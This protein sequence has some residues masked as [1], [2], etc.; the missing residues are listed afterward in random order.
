MS[1]P[2]SAAAPGAI[3]TRQDFSRALTLLRESRSLSIR[4]VAAETGVRGAHTTIGDWFSGRGLPSPA[5]RD[6]LVGVLAACG[7]SADDEVEAWLAAWRRVRRTPGPRPAGPQPYRGLAGFRPEDAGWFFGREDVVE[8]LV[9]R[10]RASRG[11]HIVVGPSGA[12]K[13]SLLGAGLVPALRSAGA[14]VELRTPGAHPGEVLSGSS[15]VLIVDQLEEMFTACRDDGERNRF[16]AALAAAAE[17]GR[18]IVLGLRADFYGHVLRYPELVAAVRDGQLALGP[19]IDDELRRAVLEPARRARV[20]VE[21]GLV[22]LLLS[23]LTPP[24]GHREAG[25]LPLLSHALYATWR[26]SDGRR[27]TIA[28]YRAVGGIDGAVATTATTVYESLTEPQRILARRLFLSLVHVAPDT[29]DTRR[30]VPAA[31]LPAGVREVLDLFIDARLVTAD[32]DT[33]QLSHEALL[34][35]WPLLRGWLDTDRAGL[36]VGRPLEEAAATWQR[37]DRD[38]AALYRGTRL[39]I[40]TEWARTTGESTAPGEQ[41]REFLAA[42]TAREQQE[43]SAR[44]RRAGRLRRLVAALLVLL[45]VAVGAT[46]AAVRS[47]GTTREQRDAALSAKVAGD[48]TALRSSDPALAAQLGLAAYRLTPTTQ[49]RGALLSTFATPYSTLLPGHTG[50]VYAAAFH[51]GGRLL[52][53]TGTDATTRLWDT[54]DPHHPHVAGTVGDPARGGVLDAGFSPDGTLLATAGA[55]GAIRLWD[56]ADPAR[57]HLTTVLGSHPGGVRRIAFR[58]DGRLIASAGT[59]DTVRLWDPGSGAA[60]ASL[61]GHTGDVSA[62]VFTPDG[63]TLVSASADTTVRLWD[64]TTPSAPRPSAVL[65]GHTDRVLAAAVSPDGRELATGGFDNTLRLWDLTKPQPRPLA[66]LTGH[67]SGIASVAFSPDG[68]TVATGSYDFTVRLW[69]VEDSAFPGEPVTLV[70]HTETVYSVAFG[71]DGRTL[72]SAG[73]DTTARLWDIGGPVLGGHYGPVIGAV[74]SPDGRLVAA[75]SYQS[76]RLWNVT[77][78][79]HPA[80]AATLHGPTDGVVDAAFT[81]DSRVLATASLDRTVRLWRLDDP[82][83]P[84]LLRV[85]TVPGENAFAVAI[86]PDGH[87]VAAGDTDSVSLWDLTTDQPPLVVIPYGDRVFSLAFSPDGHALAAGGADR[88]ARLWDVTDA[89]APAALAVLRDQPDTVHDAEFSP[90]GRLLATG[91]GHAVRLWSLADPRH[92]ELL[93]S[94]ESHSNTVSSVAFSPDSHRMAVASYDTTATLWTIADPRAPGLQATLT[95]HTDRVNSIGFSP[96]GRTVVTA[97]TDKTVRLWDTDEEAVAARI[98]AVTH[99]RITEAQWANYLPSIPYTP[100]CS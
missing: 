18:T 74:P 36:A 32:Q 79:Q 45:V 68:R 43:E 87:V 91:A 62:V 19:M 52:A 56:V 86:S 31:S 12:G 29:A 10:V 60:V 90:D 39:A 83:H 75:A 69:D 78:R 84:A 22:D 26:H 72:A 13:S 59:D 55:D 67:T 11:P 85:L 30:R 99:P 42:S 23:E 76:A 80:A 92:A 40:A 82:A 47:L 9:E 96:D 73:R 16:V 58:A 46:A 35:A 66:A 51:P 17:A 15:D 37:E 4:Q 63:R 7:V 21:D 41:A 57:P 48:S 27:L 38:P 8:L 53:T 28:G 33:V 34:S 44:R 3:H 5:S 54:S 20:A 49:A 1:E 81:P 88:A 64:V 95:G 14:V 70:G 94:A 77:D 24:G 98:C 89:R 71:P 65:T 93:S 100:P 6:L 2:T 50:A 61:T 97:G 25:G